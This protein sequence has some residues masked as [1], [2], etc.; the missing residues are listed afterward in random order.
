[1]TSPCPLRPRHRRRSATW[2]DSLRR[3][4][5]ARSVALLL[6]L[7]PL[8]ACARWLHPLEPPELF[9]TNLV[10][11]ESA[12]FEQRVRVDL[13]VLN[14]NLETLHVTGIDFEL[15]VNGTRLARGL[16]SSDV[17]VPALGESTLSVVAST[18][19]IDLVRQILRFQPEGS[20]SYEVRGRL[21]LGG[22]F[23]GTLP[24]QRS[25]T[26]ARPPPPATP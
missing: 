24:F 26:I 14:P 1:M 21:F 9:V 10:P 11:V 19:V 7:L 4:S 17:T 16:G 13:R 2:R 18:T 6:A 15:D 3:V 22:A 23:G 20:Y 12:P 8:A 5:R 25:G